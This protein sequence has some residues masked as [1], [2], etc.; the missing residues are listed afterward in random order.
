MDVRTLLPIN[1]CIGALINVNI[2]N[3]SDWPIIHSVINTPC[4]QMNTLIGH[5]DTTFCVIANAHER[6]YTDKDLPA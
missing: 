3:K 4:R 6:L 2:I 1:A 5:I